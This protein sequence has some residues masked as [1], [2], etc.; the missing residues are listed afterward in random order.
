MSGDLESRRRA[1]Y[2]RLDDLAADFAELTVDSHKA[3][4][5]D[6]DSHPALAPADYMLVIGCMFIDDEGD[7]N[8]TVLAFPRDG[9][10]PPYVTVGLLSTALSQMG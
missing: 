3:N 6:C 9:Y 2:K 1:L 5:T 8:G 4:C 7:R 10:Q